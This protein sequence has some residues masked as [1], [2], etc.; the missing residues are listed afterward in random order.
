M[1][2]CGALT[3]A[4]SRVGE[5]LVIA[6]QI[7]HPYSIAYAL[8]HNGFLALSR[9]RFE[10]CID[11]ARRLSEVAS[12]NDYVVWRTL[13]TFL[14]GVSLSALGRTEEGLAMTETAIELYQ[15][16]TTPPV[17]WPQVLALRG[18]VRTLAGDPEE[19]LNLTDQAI[20]IGAPDEATSPDFRMQRGD[21]L[22]L[23]PEP[24]LEGAE[25]A[26]LAA[27]RGSRTAGQHLVEL[28]A[29]T[30]LVSL[31]RELGHQPDGSEDLAVLY[32]TFT[33]GTDE[34]D[35]VVARQL[36]DLGSLGN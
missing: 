17:F 21:I 20:E 15:G 5:A 6:E 18:L 19:G 30:R 16:L 4:V 12:E 27:I 32:D 23:L 34:H 13:A 35:L 36:L 11:W 3:R 31:R 8:Y 29:L 26:Y 22:K 9:S 14:E 28:Q 1:W 7:D 24:D 25:Q 33:E 10:E 2:Q